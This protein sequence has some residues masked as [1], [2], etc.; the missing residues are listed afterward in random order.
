MQRPAKSL[1]SS[2]LSGQP[3]TFCYEGTGKLLLCTVPYWRRRMEKERAAAT[4]RP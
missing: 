2:W 1:C 4:A 3:R